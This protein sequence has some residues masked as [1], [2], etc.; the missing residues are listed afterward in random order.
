MKKLLLWLGFIVLLGLGIFG[1]TKLPDANRQSTDPSQQSLT[2]NSIKTEVT[3][4]SSYLFDVRTPAEFADNHFETSTNYDLQILQSGQ[5]PQ[6]PKDSKIYV[7]CHSG[8]RS[9][10][11]A[12]ILKNYGFTN[13]VD[14]GGLTDVQEI[15]GV[16]IK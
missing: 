9:S 14:L 10:Q 3:S 16:L 5:M 12:T 2:F 11:A 13:I 4:G 15:G 6:L 1:F 8:N 7:Y